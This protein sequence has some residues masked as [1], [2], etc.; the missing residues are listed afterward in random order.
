M[1][2]LVIR[3]VTVGPT[4]FVVCSRQFGQVRS[5]VGLLSHFSDTPQSA[6]GLPGITACDK[7]DGPPR[8]CAVISLVTGFSPFYS[9]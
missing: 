3:T 6:F 1:P 8:T 7:P 4:A 5:I 9:G 2:R